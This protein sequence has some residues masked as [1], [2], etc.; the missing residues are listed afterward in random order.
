[1][2]ELTTMRN[3]VLGYPIYGLP[4]VVA[5]PILDEDGDP[6]TGLTPDSEVSLN[7]DTGAD[8]TTEAAEITFTTATNRGMYQL[9][10]SAAEMTANVVTITVY[11]GA[12]TSQAT[13]IVLYPKQLP[14]IASGVAG[15]TGDDTTHIHLD[16]KSAINDFY[17]GCIVF[18]KD[19]TGANQVRMIT[20][21]V[22]A[23]CLATVAPAFAT[24]PDNTTDYEV[25]LTDVA[26]TTLLA[27]SI[28]AG[29]IVATSFAADSIVAATLA[30]GAITADAFAADAIVAATLATGAI[31]ADA[32]AANAL[33]AATFAADSLVAATFATG[34]LTADAF[35]ANAIVA[36]TLAANCITATQ[37]ADAAI[38]NATF[39]AD[40]GSTAYA[41]NIIALA[42]DKAIVERQLDHLLDVA[43]A[44]VDMTTECTDGSVISRIIS[45]SDT[46]LFVPAT[47]NLTTMFAAIVAD[48]NELQTDWV[49][50]GRLDLILDIIAA[51]TTTDIPATLA[52][53]VAAVITNA[54]GVDIAADIIALKAE[55]AL[56]VADT[57]ELQTDWHDGGRLDLILD[58]AGGA[59]DPLLNA[60]PGA[61]GVGTAGEALGFIDNLYA[62]V[63]TNAAGVDI[64]A[65]IIALKAET[66][67]IVADTNELQTDWHDGGRLDLILDIIAA[68][69]TTDIPA[70]LATLV[71]AVITNAAGVDIAADIIALKA[72]TATILAD[73]NELQGDWVNGGRLDLILD[74]IAAD[75]TTDIPATL[76]TLVAAVITNA[77]GVDIAADIIA[78][79]AET[80][81]ILADTN[82]LQTDWVNGGRLDLILDIIA[83]DTTTDIP[84]TLATLVAAVITN[85]AG[86]DIAADIIALKAETALIVADTN[87]LQTDWVN[88][89]RLDLILDII[90]ADTTTD[91][92]TTLAVIDGK[93]P[94][95]LVGGLMNS[96]AAIKVNTALAT[97]P[98]V[99]TDAVNHAP[100]A[101][102]TPTCTRSING[103]AFAAGTLANIVE[104]V[105]AV[106]VYTVDFAAA[107]LN[108]ATVVLRA[109]AAGADDTFVT[110]V[111]SP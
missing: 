30:T 10:L 72:E 76:A 45:N 29:G 85:A 59:A 66:A 18:L 55:T 47:S 83:A 92:P 64:A 82:M 60:V 61:Y 71:A 9:Q 51:D 79:K 70:T 86:V 7:G 23:T 42:A 46:S 67:L 38:D 27:A 13:P 5:F 111:T 106:G 87:E 62:A 73:T 58:A 91:I 26:L 39:A 56:I 100:M 105:G 84:A 81:T 65:D 31:T 74:I 107:D 109:T 75:T 50:G 52:T 20:D 12:A 25:Y 98:F 110:L 103:A 53:L 40:V 16:G 24:A 96:T 6:V 68:D 97:F 14:M 90:A 8:T 15:A 33:V 21:Y 101:G 80:A 88:G 32:F 54:A 77:A 41:T 48:T 22:G 95:V 4:Y 44:G 19:H 37:I 94:G 104:Q 89:G 63:I 17:N 49:N 28:G 3:D 35:A 102:L 108:G 78:L 43:T 93:L 11:T 1:M 36:A 2:A 34:C 57:N 99:M 69:T